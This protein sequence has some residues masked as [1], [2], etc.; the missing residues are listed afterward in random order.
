MVS[1]VISSLARQVKIS[2]LILKPCRSCISMC[3]ML[4]SFFLFSWPTL[5][6]FRGLPGHT[7]SSLRLERA[8]FLQRWHSCKFSPLAPPSASLRYPTCSLNFLQPDSDTLELVFKKSVV[9]RF[10]LRECTD[11]GEHFLWEGAFSLPLHFHINYIILYYIIL[12]FPHLFK[13]N[14]FYVITEKTNIYL[15][16]PNVYCYL[17]VWSFLEFI[18]MWH[19][20]SLAGTPEFASLLC[21]LLQHWW[22]AFTTKYKIFHC[23]LV[24]ST[25]WDEGVCYS[26]DLCLCWNL[27]PKFRLLIT[28][29]PFP[30]TSLSLWATHSTDS[31]YN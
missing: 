2:K 17:F 18:I 23:A 28:K 10:S 3:V 24:R 9:L 31:H 11:L 14:S 22:L 29:P 12:F 27:N 13:K 15:L 16:F 4:F 20:G 6:A 30:G 26:P 5:A 21:P 25:P 7:C 19:T 1:F 8:C